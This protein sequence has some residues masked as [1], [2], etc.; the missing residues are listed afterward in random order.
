MAPEIV[1]KLKYDARVDIWSLGVMLYI[2][3]IGKTPFNAKTKDELFH[4][5]ST[6]SINFKEPAWAKVSKQARSF[7]RSCLVRDP[8]QRPTA[9]KLLNHDWL[10]DSGEAK[11]SAGQVIEANIN[12]MNF[13]KMTVFQ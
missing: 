5:I 7:V 10:E 11:V 12:L 13:R 1:K 6:Q 2:I 8:A 4:Q 9:D 3:L